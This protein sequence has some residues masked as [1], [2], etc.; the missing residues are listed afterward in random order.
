[1]DVLCADDWFEDLFAA[2]EEVLREHAQFTAIF[3]T[4]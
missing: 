1:L 2:V 4:I 3:A